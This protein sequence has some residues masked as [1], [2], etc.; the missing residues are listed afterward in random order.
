MPFNHKQNF[1]SS[2]D[3]DDSLVKNKFESIRHALEARV[4]LGVEKGGLGKDDLLEIYIKGINTGKKEY[5][6]S[7]QLGT[8]SLFEAIL[9]KENHTQFRGS[10]DEYVTAELIHA[11]ARAISIG[12]MSSDVVTST[13]PLSSTHHSQI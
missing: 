2:I 5:Y 13:P 11:I 7:T 4:Q 10:H 12:N 9:G 3:H 1:F 6:P 8:Q